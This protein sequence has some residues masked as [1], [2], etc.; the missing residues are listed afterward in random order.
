[1]AEGWIL[2]LAATPT[3]GAGVSLVR[4]VANPTLRPFSAAGARMSKPLS[5]SDTTAAM[6]ARMAPA[7]DECGGRQG[8]GEGCLRDALPEVVIRGERLQ[9]ASARPS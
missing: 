7:L 2:H 4:V 8:S 6:I 9:S 3:G 5:S 1:M